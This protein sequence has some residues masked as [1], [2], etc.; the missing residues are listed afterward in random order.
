MH[1]RV[2][3]WGQGTEWGIFLGWQN[4]KYFWGAW[5]S[6][7]FWG[8][9]GRCWARSYVW[10]KNESTSPGVKARLMPRC[11]CADPGFLVRGVQAWRPQHGRYITSLQVY[12]PGHNQHG[13]LF[14]VFLVLNLFYSL[15]RGSNGFI[16]E[17]TILFQWSRGGQTFFRGSNFFRGGPNANFYRNPYNFRFSRG[18]G[19]PIPPSGSA[20][21]VAMI[22]HV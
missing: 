19:S 13:Q 12:I 10:R 22:S 1:F 9:N 2:F 5:N 20:H 14:W 4:F 17:K 21:E 15:Q 3:S 18:S 16:T 6:Y 11:S 7:Y 8:V